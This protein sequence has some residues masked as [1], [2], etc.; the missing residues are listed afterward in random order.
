MRIT[1]AALVTFA[2]IA[3]SGFGGCQSGSTSSWNPVTWSPWASK[4]ADSSA[5]SLASTAPTTP[6]K[7]STM[8][9]P[10]GTAAPSYTPSVPPAYPE[11][12]VERDRWGGPGGYPTTGSSS[13]NASSSLSDPSPSTP[14]MA[15]QQGHYAETAP[16]DSAIPA[17]AGEPKP[18]AL[19]RHSPPSY[20]DGGALWDSWPPADRTMAEHSETQ[21]SSPSPAE[22]ASLPRDTA[23]NARYAEGFTPGGTTPATP[24]SFHSE[25]PWGAKPSAARDEASEMA[26]TPPDQDDEF[27][28]GGTSS[29]RSRTTTPQMGAV[30]QNPYVRTNTEYPSTPPDASTESANSWGT[31]PPSQPGAGAYPTSN[32][33]TTRF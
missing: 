6:P 18:G 28:P 14:Y 30:A 11:T 16:S 33:P 26:A 19:D 12:G 7:P 3:V 27:R 25:T 2:A 21:W 8:A 1:S 4:N 22:T 23:P 10:A 5:S 24:T 13:L 20:A 15:P 32:Y 9:T 29:F 17:V 31:P